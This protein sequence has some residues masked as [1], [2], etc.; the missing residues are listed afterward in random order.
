MEELAVRR[1]D[2]SAGTL[3]GFKAAPGTSV[4]NL[5]GHSLSF[6]SGLSDPQES[7]TPDWSGIYVQLDIEQAVRYVPNQFDRGEATVCV[8]ALRVR[9]EQ[10][11][12]VIIV[13]DSRMTDVDISS[14]DKAD[15]V[16][17][18]VTDSKL[19]ADLGEAPL[20][21]A[22]GQ[23]GV[24]LCLLDCED[25]EL[26]VPHLLFNENILDA[27]PLVI[28]QE[29]KSLPS[30]VGKVTGLSGKSGTAVEEV[31]SSMR[32]GDLSDVCRLSTE[33][34]KSMENNG[35]PTTTSWLHE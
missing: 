2:L 19:C 28:F 13:N 15:I 14:A 6:A 35:L 29:S 25:Y 34:R 12:Q 16:R 26:A 1:L 8:A 18:Y 20:L 33:L 27:E 10:S 22:L 17:K 3:V 31:V 21:G 32:K 30:T 4:Q 9:Q 5:F 24:A 11:L 23:Q 7:P